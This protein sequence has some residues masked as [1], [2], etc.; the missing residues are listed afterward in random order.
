MMGFQESSAIIA[1]FGVLQE[2]LAPLLCHTVLASAVGNEPEIPQHRKAPPRVPQAIDQFE[3]MRVR[4]LDLL[5]PGAVQGN[6]CGSKRD[7]D[8]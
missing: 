8:V 1:G 7:T 5:G 3:R 2:A 6:Q 4:R